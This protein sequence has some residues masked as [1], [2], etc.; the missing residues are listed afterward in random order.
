L[1]AAGN[2]DVVGAEVFALVHQDG[3]PV[4][5]RGPD[6]T[7]AF[8]TLGPA[9]AD[10]EATRTEFEIGGRVSAKVHGTA[11]GVG[12][13]HAVAGVLDLAVQ[14]AHAEPC[15]LQEGLDATTALAH[16]G[17]A[18]DARRSRHFR[19]DPVLF[20]RTSPGLGDAVLSRH[21]QFAAACR[22][23]RTNLPHVLRE[24]IPETHGLSSSCPG[25][26]AG[27]SAPAVFATV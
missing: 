1:A 14:L 4:D 19:I 15:Q 3:C 7:G 20:Q 8:I 2:A 24:R 22:R 18:Q 11:L 10:T 23:Q 13:Q 21:S 25:V 16:L 27:C 5:Q 12:H 17:R 6:A 26:I 9:G